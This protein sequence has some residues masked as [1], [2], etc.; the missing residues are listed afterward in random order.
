MNLEQLGFDEF[1]KEKTDPEKFNQFSIAR[2]IAVNKNSCIITTSG[3]EIFAELTGK[4]LFDADSPLDYPTTGDFV[5]AQIF[6][7]NSFAVIHDLLPRKSV[8]KRKMPGK[9][10]DFQLIASNINTA[11]VVQALGGDY[12]IRRL[13]RYLVMIIEGNIEPLLLLSKSDLL[14][15]EEIENKIAEI[16]NLFPDLKV[17][18]FSNQNDHELEKVR[19]LFTAGKTYC[20]VGSSGVGKTTLLNNLIHSQ[21]FETQPVRNSD[22]RGRHTTTR[23]ELIF[24]DNG[25]ML[26][27]TPGM[28][29][30]GIISE[31]HA[32]DESFSD[33]AAL[34]KQ[35]RFRD[36]THIKEEGCA[37]L[38]AVENGKLSQER[39]NSYIKLMKESSFNQMSYVEKRRK[40]K[41]FGKMVKS[42]LKDHPKK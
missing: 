3:N 7:D 39:Y 34:T 32:I 27:D 12:N 17:I 31:E 16:H 15:K 1:F 4:F 2:V 35:C 9:K 33:A 22:Q 42:I 5:Y 21:V 6:N 41:E 28:R 11:M 30:L 38:E 19:E 8:L 26:I 20:L 25:A 13:E 36:C 40:D 29:E 18:A 14:S 23:R 37:L 24:L 10:V